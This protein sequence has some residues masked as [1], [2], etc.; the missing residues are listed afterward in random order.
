M[1]LYVRA[2]EINF[3]DGE[4]WLELSEEGARVIEDFE[5]DPFSRVANIRK[6][7]EYEIGIY[8][9]K[10]ISEEAYTQRQ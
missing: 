3:D 6:G 9:Y 4:A 2:K 5:P 1:V 10:V 7:Y 8:R